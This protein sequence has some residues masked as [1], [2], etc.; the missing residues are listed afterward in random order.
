MK[1][2]KKK[3]KTTPICAV[4]KLMDMIRDLTSQM[5]RE[6]RDL[7]RLDGA[8][9]SLSLSE[10][11]DACHI[12]DELLAF[13]QKKKKAGRQRERERER[14]KINAWKT[15][16]SRRQAGRVGWVRQC[17]A[18]RAQRR[19]EGVKGRH[20]MINHLAGALGLE[21]LSH[22]HTSRQK[23]TVLKRVCFN[24]KLFNLISTVCILVKLSSGRQRR[25]KRI[26]F[27]WLA[28]LSVCHTHTHT[29]VRQKVCRAWPVR[30]LDA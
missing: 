13:K 8:A 5:E 26:A 7:W 17:E 19:R 21:T 12:I 3:P 1:T 2:G 15:C 6:K 16:S 23:E 10:K 29:R 25:L 18:A 28:W 22:T 11:T 4:I 20:K 14:R 27:I 30:T 24:K 9:K